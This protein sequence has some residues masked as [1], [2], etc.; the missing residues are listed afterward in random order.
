VKLAF[1]AT[2]YEQYSLAARIGDDDC[3]RG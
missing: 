1:V 2:E 3:N